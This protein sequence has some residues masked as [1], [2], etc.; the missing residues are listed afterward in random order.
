MTS[1]QQELHKCETRTFYEKVIE[2]F[3]SSSGLEIQLKKRTLET[4][5]CAI[6]E[7]KKRVDEH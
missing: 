7:G 1:A 2:G 4:Y 6:Q 5:D 3:D